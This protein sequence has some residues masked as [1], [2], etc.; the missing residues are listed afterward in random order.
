MNNKFIKVH[1]SN[2]RTR[3]KYFLLKDEFIDENILKNY[4]EKIKDIKSVRINKKA[5]SI[6]FELHKD[7][8]K[9][10]EEILNKLTIED[11]LK[12]CEDEV[13]AVCISCVGSEEPSINGIV[14]A[15][16]ALIAERFV[17]NDLLKAGYTNS[18]NFIFTRF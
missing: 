9:K 18:S 15:T 12:S 17:A 4:F 10:I 8:S 14:R 16:S 2:L 1:Q 11:L 7:I 5:F 3:Y 6:I 13:A